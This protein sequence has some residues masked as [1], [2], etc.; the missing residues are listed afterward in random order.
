MNTTKGPVVLILSTFTIPYVISISYVSPFITT[1]VSVWYVKA[2]FFFNWSLS[3]RLCLL[4]NEKYLASTSQ[5]QF[6]YLFSSVAYK[7]QVN[8]NSEENRSNRSLD[9]SSS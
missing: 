5:Q 3:Q 9:V 2:V 1:T 6:L 7:P 4:L 8:K